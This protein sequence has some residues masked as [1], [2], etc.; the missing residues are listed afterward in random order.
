MTKITDALSALTIRCLQ[1][2]HQ[3]PLDMFFENVQHFYF[4]FSSLET[5]N[6]MRQK[7]LPYLCAYF[8]HHNATNIFEKR[9]AFVTRTWCNIS[10]LTP[11]NA[12]GFSRKRARTPTSDFN[13]SFPFIRGEFKLTS[14]TSAAATH[15]I[16]V[17]FSFLLVTV[18]IG[19]YH[20]LPPLVISSCFNLRM[21]RFYT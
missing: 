9:S 11:V 10:R 1:I 20:D 18:K 14:F 6:R 2:S 17:L 8:C 13:K 21:Y 7:S 19:I 16:L 3:Q 12:I 5:R 4:L 15:T